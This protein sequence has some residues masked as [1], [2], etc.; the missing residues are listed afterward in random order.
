[1]GSL[2]AS[3]EKRQIL[4]AYVKS[5]LEQVAA[6]PVPDGQ[7]GMGVYSPLF[8]VQKKNRAWR[9]VIDLTHLNRFIR[10]ER[11]RMETLSTFQQS[12]QPAD[13]L[14]SIDLK[15]A[16]FHVPVEADFQQFL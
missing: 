9:P 4:S 10:K 16:Y 3:E 2:P 6:I 12:V 5:L 11:F 8:M 14:V 7:R 13:W 1:M 15:D